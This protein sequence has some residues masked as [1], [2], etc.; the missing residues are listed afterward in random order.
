MAWYQQDIPEIF[1]RL[2][3]SEH[4]LDDSQ[5]KELLQRYGPNTIAEPDKISKIKLFFH[6][7]A[8]P[9]IYILILAAGIT[10]Y[11]QEYKDASVIIAVI[12]FNALIGFFQEFKAEKSVMALKQMTAPKARVLRQG[13]ERE[14]ASELLVPGDVVLLESGVKVPADLRLF[15]TVELRVDEAILTGE[16]LPVEKTA[17][18]LPEENLTPGDQKNMAFLGTV[19]L[20]GRGRGVVVE[21]GEHT[22][23]GGI[24]EE[25]KRITPSQAPLQKKF[26]RFANVLGLIV[27]AASAL[28][29]L[30]GVLTGE[31]A[32]DMFMT[33]VAAAVAAIPEGLPV[34][35]TITLARS[36]A[37]MAKRNAIIRKLPAVET[38]GSTTVICS[39]KTGTLTKNEMTVKLIYDG[40]KAYEVTGSGYQPTGE[41][42]QAWLPVE[43]S[44]R[45]DLE[46]VLRIG[47]LCNEAELY[48]EDD[49][50]KVSGD[51]TEGALIVSALK[52]GLDP[53]TERELY[54]QLAAIPFESDWGY[55]ATLHQFQ[56]KKYMFVKGAPEKVVNMCTECM[57]GNGDKMKIIMRVADNLAKDGLR[58]LAM[59]FKEVPPETQE[60]THQDVAEGLVVAGLQGMIDPPREEVIEAIAGCRRAG[61]RVIMITGD[62]AVTAQAIAHKLGIGNADPQ[63]FTGRQL[64]QIGD[65]ELHEKVKEVSVFAR[66]A[67]DH[68][69]RI[70]EQLLKHGEIV[71][72]T[73]DGV[74]DTPALKAAHIG[75]AMGKSGTDV[76]KEAADMVIADDNFASIF[77]AVK[78]G[79][80]V[81]DNIRKVTFFLI[82]TGVAAILSIIGTVILG[83]PMPYLPAQ[84]LWINLVTNGFQVIALA[85]EP[86]EKDVDQ[87]PPRN[88]REGIMSSILIQRTIIVGVLIAVG[89]IVKFVYA[90]KNGA[91]LDQARTMTVTTMVF[92]QFFQA[93]NSRSEF[94]SVF[95]LS[96]FAN[97]FLLYALLASTFAHL[98][99]IYA[100]PLQWVFRTVPL[101]AF[102]W[103]LVLGISSSVIVVVEIDKAIRRRFGRARNQNQRRS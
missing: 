97:P 9:L 47:L 51:P 16:S 41:I 96:P 73:G 69:L 33:V 50:Y 71:A 89:V 21:T 34:V 18:A 103:L 75:V 39:D 35:V 102:D 46:R 81:F 63:V 6:Q 32:Q 22:I 40:E 19:V 12:L 3:T 91:D 5:A 82:P 94:H 76:A 2:G 29:F 14:I 26:A 77:W 10:V 42:L 64:E 30:L 54:P 38:L 25:V 57:F 67:P 13:H 43:M 93:I 23:L 65:D 59:A 62:H 84:L 83:L 44:A 15:R 31:A 37:L 48:E 100:S 36:V 70:T 95:R 87:R 85:F 98:A 53:I 4:G 27:L 52:G 58:V 49:Q 88:P 24:A 17:A 28:L 74:N 20:M 80:I 86:G 61:I 7:F 56:D 66:V 1:S 8:S 45:G 99:V 60:I 55:M 11:L 90:L 78:E 101:S 68:K 72:V 79:R 92:F